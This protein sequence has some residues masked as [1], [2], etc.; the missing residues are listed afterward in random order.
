MRGYLSFN[1]VVLTLPSL[2]RHCFVREL[3][4][5]RLSPLLGHLITR[6]LNRF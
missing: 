1:R 2:E 6:R 5:K 3:G 4:Q